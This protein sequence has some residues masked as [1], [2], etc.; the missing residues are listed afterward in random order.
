MSYLDIG[1][2]EGAEVLFG[3]EKR[4]MNGNFSEVITLNQPLS[5]VIIQ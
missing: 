1:K 5:R 3:G 4:E 2:Q